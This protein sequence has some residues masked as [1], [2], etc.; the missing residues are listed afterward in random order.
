MVVVSIRGV[1]ESVCVGFW[2]GGD[3]FVFVRVF[4]CMGALCFFKQCWLIFGFGGCLQAEM[5]TICSS[6]ADTGKP[7]LVN[8]VEGGK[9]PLLSKEKYIECLGWH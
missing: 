9:T 1:C 6:L 3:L 4:L 5:R 8:C 7:L 2:F